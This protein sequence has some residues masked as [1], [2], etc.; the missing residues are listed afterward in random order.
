[1]RP[2]ALWLAD[3]VLVL[4]AR[5]GDWTAALDTLGAAARQRPLPGERVRHHRGV[6]LYELS[7]AAERRDQAKRAAALAAKAQALAPDLAPI[8]CHHARLLLGLGRRRAA[9]KAVERA[10]RNAPHPALARLYLDIQPEAAPLAR[11]AVL[12]RLA[13]RNPD[14]AESHL[15]IAE[16]AL[17]AQ[18]WGEARRHLTVAAAAAPPAGPSRRLCLLMARLE[19]GETGNAAAARQWLDR[20]IGAPGDPRYECS[21]CGSESALWQPLCGECGGFD[22]LLWRSPADGAKANPP[23]ALSA[24]PLM[25]PEPTVPATG[26]AAPSRLAST[27]Q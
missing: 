6:V 16:A 19:E 26:S 17:A 12:Q 22:T 24:A 21:R 10:W 2:N 5:A 27:T 7:R 15:A 25:L 20:A 18:L 11:A 13:A 1:V 4:Q 14:A 8:A 23:P 9:A 3:S